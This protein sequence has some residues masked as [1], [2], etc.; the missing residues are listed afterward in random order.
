MM[1][2]YEIY[3]IT[4]PGL[5]DGTDV[6]WHTEGRVRKL[7]G[8][9]EIHPHTIAYIDGSTGEII[10]ILGDKRNAFEDVSRDKSRATDI[11][12][13]HFARF[14]N[15]NEF[16]VLLAY[17][18]AMHPTKDVDEV[19]KM[20]VSAFDTGAGHEWTGNRPSRGVLIEITYP[21]TGAPS[22]F[23]EGV[24]TASLVQEYF[25]PAQFVSPS[26]GSMQ[27]LL[28]TDGSDPR[29]LLGF[30][31]S[32]VAPA[33]PNIGRGHESRIVSLPSLSEVLASIYKR[34]SLTPPPAT[35]PR[36][37]NISDPA[38]P[39]S[40]VSVPVY[41]I[42]ERV[43]LARARDWDVSYVDD[44]GFRNTISSYL[45][46]DHHGHRPFDEDDFLDGLINQPTD[47]CSE[48]LVHT[49][50]AYGSFNYSHVDPENGPIIFR[51][52]WSRAKE[53]W[54]GN[55]DKENSLGS[56]AA[57]M[58][59]WSVH[60]LL[61]NDN[62]G[63]YDVHRAGQVLSELAFRTDMG[64]NTPPPVG[65]PRAL[66]NAAED[67][68][69]WPWPRSG[70]PVPMLKVETFLAQSP[71]SRII[72]DIVPLL[73]QS[74]RLPTPD[75]QKATLVLYQRMQKCWGS[76]HPALKVLNEAPLH[77]LYLK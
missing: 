37:L 50:P 53:L 36:I 8:L 35:S 1:T 74:S 59:M 55:I 33:T 14:H 58:I 64:F 61:T 49:I 21:T 60:T 48:V 62:L 56:A 17:K 63:L 66:V 69:P 45:N 7:S 38:L 22:G 65:P 40:P 16:S 68:S 42:D 15:L 46:W 34:S 27:I 6:I 76:I 4:S 11:A 18:I 57:G 30:G 72:K 47:T 13:Q 2:I 77:V 41:V 12:Y 32:T 25:H 10:W 52:A 75:Y 23:V 26:Q 19:N 20:L 70:R 31:Y 67:W 39:A 28:S 43:K 73:K 71:L 51:A 29:V 44:H 9:H 54:N 3:P 24:Y 5:V